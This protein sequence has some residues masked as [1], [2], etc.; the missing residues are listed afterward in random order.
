MTLLFTQG[1]S[2][3]SNLTNVKLVLEIIAIFHMTLIYNRLFGFETPDQN[4]EWYRHLLYLFAFCF[5]E[6]NTKGINFQMMFYVYLMCMCATFELVK[7]PEVIL[8][9]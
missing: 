5:Y 3:V 1:H 7:S 4:G 9:S 8:C 2:C 6:S